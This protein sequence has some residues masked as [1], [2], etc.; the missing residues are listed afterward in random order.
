MPYVPFKFSFSALV[1]GL[2][3]SKMLLLAFRRHGLW[4]EE[5]VLRKVALLASGEWW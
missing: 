5:R 3:A 4:V 2:V 1:A